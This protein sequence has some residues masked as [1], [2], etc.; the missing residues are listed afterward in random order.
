MRPN[1]PTPPKGAC[2]FF[3]RF[4]KAWKPTLSA[5][6]EEQVRNQRTARMIGGLPHYIGASMTIFARSGTAD[7]STF[8]D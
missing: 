4:F 8:Y 2:S 1:G 7:T 3:A 5:D 6:N